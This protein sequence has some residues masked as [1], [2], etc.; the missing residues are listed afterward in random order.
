MDI[1]NFNHNEAPKRT[2]Q[3]TVIDSLRFDEGSYTILYFHTL[4]GVADDI[5]V[6][7]D[8]VRQQ[9]RDGLLE[10]LKSNIQLKTYKERRMNFEYRYYS[11]TTGKLLMKFR[12][13]AEDYI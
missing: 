11:K 4:E 2:D 7:T 8:D 13:S 6:L 10:H 1:D 12:F 9:Q 3:V 5:T